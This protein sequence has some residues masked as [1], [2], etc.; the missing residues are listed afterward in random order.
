MLGVSHNCTC[1]SRVD[2]LA[3]NPL[4][5][6]SFYRAKLRQATESDSEGRLHELGEAQVAVS[7]VLRPLSVEITECGKSSLNWLSR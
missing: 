7:E 6:C 3:C 5:P 1:V 2:V 4:P